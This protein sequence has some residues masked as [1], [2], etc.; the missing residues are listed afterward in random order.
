MH[1]ARKR[2]AASGATPLEI[3]LEMKRESYADLQS[4]ARRLRAT[5]GRG[6]DK[7]REELQA[8]LR[9]ARSDTQA[10]ARDAAPYVHPK[11]QSVLH[12][13]DPEM[14]TRVIHDISEE[15]LKRAR[16]IILDG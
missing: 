9:R 4:I 11:R 16:A 13:E 8:I 3:M 10:F 14:P 2:V 15:S 12:G 7:A 6:N 1:R 5:T